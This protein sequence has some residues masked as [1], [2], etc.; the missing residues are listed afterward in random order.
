MTGSSCVAGKL[1]M[2]RNEW[3]ERRVILGGLVGG[4]VTLLFA[5]SIVFLLNSYLPELY[6]SEG[7]WVLGLLP[8]LLAPMAGGF[9]AGVI[10]RPKVREAGTIAG[11]L[12][13]GVI[14]VGWLVLMGGSFAVVLRGAVIAL[15]V[16]LFARTFSGFARVR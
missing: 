14:L 12:A 5:F 8:A 6:T 4:V 13:G 11:G 7:S 10:A 16:F 2:E 3:M 1:D 9:L 15:V